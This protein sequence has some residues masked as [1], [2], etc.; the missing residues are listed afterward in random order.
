MENELHLLIVDDEPNI[1]SGLA[2]GLEKICDHIETAASVNEALDKFVAGSFQLVIADVKMPGDRDGLD[3]LRW[4]KHRDPS[5]MSII[6]TANGTVETAVDAMKW[7]AFDFI[8][9]PVD[10]NLIRQQVTKAAEHHRLQHE[11]HQ[12]KEKLAEAG[13]LSGIVGNCDE[14]QN[15]LKQVRQVAS[16]DATVLIQGESGTGKELIAR[17]IHDLSARSKDPFVAVNLG[18]LPESLLESEM[19]GH[20]KGAF[21]GASRQKPGCFEQAGNGTLFL[22]EIT[23][24]PAKSQVD[25]LRVL[26]TG[27]FARVGGEQML[28]SNARII[29]AT[30]RDAMTLVQDGSFRDDLFYRL[31]IVPIEV[32][33]LRSRREDIPLLV[34]HFLTRF[35][36]RHRRSMK[37]LTPE[38]MEALMASDWPGN[39]RQLRNHIERIVVTVGGETIGRNDLPEEHQR[40]S[41]SPCNAIRTLNEITEMAERT[42]IESA[43]TAKDFHRERT[44]KALGISVR[45]LHYKMNRYGLH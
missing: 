45:T 37:S 17:A 14:F 19:F 31:N 29:S 22:D 41:V 39:V 2:R 27:Q 23:E 3:L 32:P 4:I 13:E 20:E 10:L 40:Q 9:K 28:Q 15:L 8:T 18:A 33:P 25:L 5:V 12:L 24:I 11:N 26:E 34:E 42:G 35:C 21:T 30:N 1:R 38:A 7:G 44:A 16:T 36:T 6:I 43:L